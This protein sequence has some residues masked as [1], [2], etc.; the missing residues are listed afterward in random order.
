M[1]H[2]FSIDMMVACIS[3]SVH[4]SFPILHKCNVIHW[5]PTT[6]LML[7]A[8]IMYNFYRLWG[9]SIILGIIEESSLFTYMCIYINKLKAT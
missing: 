9:P 7:T 8:S 2:N 4:S 5:M 1:N 6:A 3:S